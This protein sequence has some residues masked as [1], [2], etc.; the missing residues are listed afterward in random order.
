MAGTTSGTV[1][2]MATTEATPPAV[3]TISTHRWF[4]RSEEPSVMNESL[5]AAVNALQVH[6]ESV[7]PGGP[8]INAMQMQPPPQ[9]HIQAQ[10]IA[11]WHYNNNTSA[12]PSDPPNQWQAQQVAHPQQWQAQHQNP[13]QWLIIKQAATRQGPVNATLTTAATT[14]GRVSTAAGR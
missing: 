13:Q 6:M 11:G 10:Q 5:Q 1:T 12:P 14:T 9:A 8:A 4:F 2:A 7:G 3:A